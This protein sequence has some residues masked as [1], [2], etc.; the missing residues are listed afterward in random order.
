MDLKVGS[1]PTL[2]GAEKLINEFYYSTTYRITDGIVYNSKG[3][4]DN[5]QIKKKKNRFYITVAN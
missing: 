5:I 2:E 1:S 3:V 4:C